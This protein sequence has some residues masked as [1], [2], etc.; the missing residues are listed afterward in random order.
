[1]T[2]HHIAEPPRCLCIT[3]LHVVAVGL[4]LIG[5]V[6]APSVRAQ[7]PSPLT[8]VEALGLDTARIGRVTV[9]FAPADRERA[10]ELAALSEAV[11]AMFERELG[12]SFDHRVAALAPEHWFSE[13]P[14]V[15]YAIPWASMPERLLFVP[16]SLSEGFMVR[17]PTPL[18]DRR[19]IDFVL[20]HEYGHLADEA[21]FQP[22]RGQDYERAP[23]F[24]ELLASYF[25]YA[26]VHASDPAWAEAG[27]EMWRGVLAGYT[28]PVL[29]LEWGFMNDLPPDDLAR[30]YAW[31]QNLLN[32][33]AAELYEAH[34][35]DFL[36]AAKEELAWYWAGD[37]TAASLLPSLE[38]F[39]PGFETW[40]EN[41]ESGAYLP[42]DDD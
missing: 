21:Y 22:T 15:P 18:H 3:P 6:S 8:R 42:R 4:L 26:F 40:V 30:T 34:G 25:A 37:R 1:M 24:E 39:A 38:A 5:F 17:G 7:D 13:F 11:A 33:R 12:V 23:W 29:S 9:Y 31:Y 16:S 2:E 28:P 36:R 35:M 32:L 41:L 19:R 14:G 10:V 27:K 20:L